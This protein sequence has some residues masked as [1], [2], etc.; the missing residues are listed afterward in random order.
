MSWFTTDI[1]DTGRLP[2][3]LCFTAFVA[4]FVIPRELDSGRVRVVV[5]SRAN[6]HASSAATCGLL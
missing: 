5:E 1:V 3:F 6:D 4:T 2:L